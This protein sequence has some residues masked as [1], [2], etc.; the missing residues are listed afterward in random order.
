MTIM[1]TAPRLLQIKWANAP[2]HRTL[3]NLMVKNTLKATSHKVFWVSKLSLNGIHLVVSPKKHSRFLLLLKHSAKVC[4]LPTAIDTLTLCN[5][6]SIL[7]ISV[8]V[9]IPLL[10]RSQIGLFSRSFLG[11]FYIL[12]THQV[13]KLIVRFSTDLLEAPAKRVKK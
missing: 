12:F 6:G 4:D 5:P 3:N 2:A 13:L 1:I 9:F 7:L 8:T 11:R 10:L